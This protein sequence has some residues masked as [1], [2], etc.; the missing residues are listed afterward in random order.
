[1]KAL[2]VRELSRRT[3]SVLDALERGESFE[4]HRNGRAVGYL[5]HTA[6]SPDRGPDWATHFRWLR[7]QSTGRS[8]ALL[9]E[10]DEDRRRQAAREASLE[11]SR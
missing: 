3:A 11:V 4:V 7:R 8:E 9:E 1:M 5:T 10:F 2:T 6:P